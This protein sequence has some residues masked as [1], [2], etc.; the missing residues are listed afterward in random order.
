MPV[1]GSLNLNSLQ[2]HC[3]RSY[4]CVFR[5][6]QLP[7]LYVCLS[8]DGTRSSFKLRKGSGSSL[9]LVPK[10]NRTPFTAPFPHVV[11]YISPVGTSPLIQVFYSPWPHYILI[12]KP[13]TRV[14]QLCRIRLLE[15]FSARILQQM[16]SL[17]IALLDMYRAAALGCSIES[18]QVPQRMLRRTG[19][20]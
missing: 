14:M 13:T 1:F 16:N 19:I 11:L 18:P 7:L 4:F 8:N 17:D 20:V 15:A 9:I 10:S 12:S 5:L 2:A 3:D 6:S